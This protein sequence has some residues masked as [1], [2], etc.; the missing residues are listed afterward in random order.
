MSK[1][2]SNIRLLVAR[3]TKG[4]LLELNSIIELLKVE[5]EAREAGFSL[6]THGLENRKPRERNRVNGGKSN[7]TGA[8]LNNSN[9]QTLRLT[10]SY[11]YFP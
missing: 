6:K 4:S 9:S 3:K 8:F 11:V 2:P 10:I 1:L 5:V 7:V